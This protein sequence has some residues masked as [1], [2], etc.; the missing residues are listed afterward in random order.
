LPRGARKTAVA[1]FCLF[2]TNAEEP[3][4]LTDACSEN[5]RIK[6]GIDSLG[7]GVARGSEFQLHQ[8]WRLIHVRESYF[9]RIFRRNYFCSGVLLGNLDMIF[10]IAGAML[11]EKLL[12]NAVKI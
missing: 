7:I 5:K 10:Y 3:M 1:A 2:R 6:L 8:S 9:C 4:H 11:V 12:Q